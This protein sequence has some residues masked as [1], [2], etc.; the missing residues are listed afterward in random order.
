MSQCEFRPAIF[1]W[2]HPERSRSLVDLRLQPEASEARRSEGS[3]AGRLRLRPTPD[4]SPTGE[5]AGLRDDDLLQL[6][7]HI[8]EIVEALFPHEPFSAA[9]G[10]FGKASARLGVVAE[11]DAVGGRFKHDLVQANNFALAE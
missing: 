4:P 1:R 6:P 11:V 7:P 3:S 5:S 9:D 10:A 8:F 2:R